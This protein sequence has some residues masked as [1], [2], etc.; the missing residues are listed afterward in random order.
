MV[1]MN[2]IGLW[3]SVKAHNDHNL[4]GVVYMHRYYVR[5]EF[6][7]STGNIFDP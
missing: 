6:L 7:I 4:I 2:N 1:I 3:Y 5:L